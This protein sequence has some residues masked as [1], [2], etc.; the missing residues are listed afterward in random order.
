MV[1]SRWQAGTALLVAVCVLWATSLTHAGEGPSRIQPPEGEV[2]AEA[3]IADGLLVRPFGV[4]ATV[5]GSVAFVLMLPFSI[6][7]KSVNKTA[8]K[9]VVDPA[10]YTFT[11]P[12]GQL[13]SQKPS[14]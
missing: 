5:L 8:Q 2:S 14:R 13:D 11:R 10:K 12:L 3:I 9:L 7:T 1:R 4:A 6:P